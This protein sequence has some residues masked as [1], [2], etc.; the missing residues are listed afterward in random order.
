MEKKFKQYEDK[1]FLLAVSGGVDSMVMLDTFIKA[2]PLDK[3]A[4]VSVNHNLRPEGAFDCN[5]VK[6]YCKERGVRFFEQS[7]NVMQFAVDAKISIETAARQ[8]R[9]KV[10]EEVADLYG[11]DLI[12]LAHHAEDNAETV[13][14]HLLRGGGLRGVSGIRR[15]QGRFFRPILKLTKADILRY[16]EENQIPYVVDK[17][18]SDTAYK[19]NYVRHEILPR[20]KELN[21]NAIQALNNFASLAQEEDEFLD[22]LVDLDDVKFDQRKNTASFGVTEFNQLPKVLKARFLRKI[23]RKLGYFKDIEQKHILNITKLCLTTDGESHIDL[24]FSLIARRSYDTLCICPNNEIK[25]NEILQLPFGEGIFEF[26]ELKLG[27]FTTPPQDLFY[28]TVDKDKIPFGAV[29]RTRKTGDLFKKFGSG[30]KKLKDY[31]ID[32]KI[33]QHLRDYLPIIAYGNTVYAVFGCEISDKAKVT[34]DTK[35]Q[36]FISIL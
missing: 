16:A 30:E 5:F 35:N 27:V 3:F 11:Y 7:V 28:L 12:C 22:S 26:G 15:C 33:P 32:V 29:V 1:K 20:L 6:E 10:I 21:P 14:M 13:L 23:M 36:L 2:L 4:V 25:T 9:Y 18:N 17:T 31:F 34:P 19:R 24:P 8:L